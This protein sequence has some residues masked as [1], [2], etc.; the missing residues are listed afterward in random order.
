[1]S[2][3]LK[4]YSSNKQLER[5][6]RHFDV[7]G[8]VKWKIPFLSARENFE[9]SNRNFW[10]SGSRPISL[11][12]SGKYFYGRWRLPCNLGF[13]LFSGEQLER[14][15]P[16]SVTWTMQPISTNLRRIGNILF[17]SLEVASGRYLPS[18]EKRLGKYPPLAITIVLV[19]TKTVR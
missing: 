1:M 8:S 16:L 15:N 3:Y 11:S 13:K 6:T 4:S 18:R 9:N 5:Q 10:L 12:G 17:T 14:I 2:V 7:T 19:Y